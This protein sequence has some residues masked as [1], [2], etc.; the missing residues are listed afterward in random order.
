MATQEDW[1]TPTL[2]PRP[3]RDG[4]AWYVELTWPDG[5]VEHIGDFG[6]KTT[7]CDWI[8]H[9]FPSFFRDKLTH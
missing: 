8:E 3:L 6:S 4:S 9:D 2:R 5:R 7:A 1:S